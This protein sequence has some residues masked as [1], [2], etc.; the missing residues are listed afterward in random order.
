MGYERLG[1]GWIL[2]EGGA[3]FGFDETGGNG[4]DLDVVGTHFAGENF[5]EHDEGG[6]ADAVDTHHGAGANAGNRSHVDNLTAALRLH[7]A[8]SRLA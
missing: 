7:L 5:G 8:N 3:E 1:N 4:I 2:P 6:F